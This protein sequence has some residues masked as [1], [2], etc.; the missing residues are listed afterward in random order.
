MEVDTA[1]T[2]ERTLNQHTV[3]LAIQLDEAAD[4]RKLGPTEGTDTELGSQIPSISQ[5]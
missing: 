1:Q 3:F 5:S 4:V 2:A